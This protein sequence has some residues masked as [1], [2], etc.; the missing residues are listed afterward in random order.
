VLKVTQVLKVPQVPFQVHKVVLELKEDKV[1]KVVLE[2]KEDKV[3]KELK[4]IQE[5]QV[6]KAP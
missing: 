2:L 3:L 4:V 5:T 6:L 1:H